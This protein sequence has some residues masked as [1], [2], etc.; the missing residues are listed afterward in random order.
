MNSVFNIS[1]T[2]FYL[3]AYGRFRTGPKGD[4]FDTTVG[5]TF[6]RFA[7]EV[8]RNPLKVSV[9]GVLGLSWERLGDVLQQ[10]GGVLGASWDSWCD[11]LEISAEVG[12]KMGARRAKLVASCAQRGAMI[13]VSW[14]KMAPRRP[15]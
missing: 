15:G 1:H 10:L 8:F 7:K 13:A 12:A 3:S 2:H 4:D 11:F 14:A 5:V 6:D 9:W